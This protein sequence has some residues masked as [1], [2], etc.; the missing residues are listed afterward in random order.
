MLDK[1]D[2]PLAVG[3][4]I[5]HVERGNMF[6]GLVV[7]ENQTTIKY[8]LL[9]EL[10]ATYV[11]LRKYG[12][13]SSNKVTKLEMTSDIMKAPFRSWYGELR[14]GTYEEAIKFTLDEYYKSCQ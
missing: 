14:N 13:K 12:V 10:D 11:H 2:R 3:D 9:N 4:L 1:F 8:I 7:E 6:P 5:M